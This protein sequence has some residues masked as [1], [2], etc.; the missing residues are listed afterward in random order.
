[1]PR[2]ASLA[3][4]LSPLV[5]AAAGRGPSLDPPGQEN[6]LPKRRLRSRG[7][8]EAA[9]SFLRGIL[10]VI[11][12]RVHSSTDGL[13]RGRISVF[14]VLAVKYSGVISAEGALV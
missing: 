8:P 4:G 14:A 6:K 5:S 11:I 10:V 3:V 13:S 1:M 7:N 9:E 2:G 12:R